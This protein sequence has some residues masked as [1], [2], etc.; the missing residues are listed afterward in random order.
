[1]SEIVIAEVTTKKQRKA[2][3]MYPFG[4][5]ARKEFWVPPLIMDQK[6][7]F[8]PA[9]GTYFE[10]SEVQLFLAYRDDKI[11]GRISAHSNTLHNKTH[12]DKIGFFGFY[13]SIDD[14]KVAD[15]L[16]NTAYNWLKAKGFDIM[17]G[18]MNFSVN[19]EIGLLVDGYHSPSFLMNV[20]NKEY[21]QQ[22]FENWGL[23]K[24]MDIY[25]Y[26]IQIKP[27]AERIARIGKL[28]QKRYGFEIKTLPVKDKQKQK[29]FLDKVF[30]VYRD[31]WSDNWGYVPMTPH[32]FK[33]T[34]DT[35][36]QFAL[37]EFVYIAERGEEVM[38]TF[39]CL[40][41][42]NV[43]LKKLNGRLL[44]FG[45][46]KLLYWRNKITGLRVPIMGVSEPYR[47]KGVDIAFYARSF[48]T[49][50]NHKRQW[51]TGEFSWILENNV[52]MNRMSRTLGGEIDKT[53]RI[54]DKAI[55]E[56][57]TEG[58]SEEKK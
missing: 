2:F 16:F 22:L 28:A 26:R 38:G 3:I 58:A 5:Y 30:K 21:Y 23:K 1:M 51:L 4:L 34:V 20:W 39:V 52:M 9:K 33:H 8:D 43:V 32:E 47:N 46:F 53:Y 10:H 27:V 36:I 57:I 48:E 7:M 42:Y 29:D 18:P 12:N 11:V 17:R 37:P 45:I 55:R 40:P 14:Q 15:A 25:A 50:M 49:A 19:E 35:L 56:N 31:A 41:D 54:Y 24:S 44:P 13:E 6:M